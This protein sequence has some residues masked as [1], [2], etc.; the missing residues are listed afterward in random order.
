MIS[1]IVSSYKRPRNLNKLIPHLK[2]NKLISEIIILHGHKDY[3][4]H[5]DGCKNI[6]DWEN[7]KKLFTLC[8]FKAAALANNEVVLLND[9][10]FLLSEDL[11]AQMFNAYQEDVLGFYGFMRKKCNC[12][13]YFL[14]LKDSI[15][16]DYNIIL[17]NASIASKGTYM[18]VFKNMYAPKYAELF[19]KVIAQR[20]GCEDLFFNRVYMDVYQKAPTPVPALVDG[21]NGHT[22]LDDRNGFCHRPNHKAERSEFCKKY[23][24]K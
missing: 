24:C 6:D 7:N 1:V 21:V 13:G 20:G 5:F 11:V 17:P 12:E 10:D 15:V 16:K 4:K 19:D 18:N 3:V 23:F 9:D 14:W 8:R 22:N 2:N